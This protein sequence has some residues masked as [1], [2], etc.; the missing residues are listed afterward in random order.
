M[1]PSVGDEKD[2][3]MPCIATGLFTADVME[4]G[5]AL[6]ESVFEESMQ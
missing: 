3:S 5:R 4:S 1:N 2:A 6:A